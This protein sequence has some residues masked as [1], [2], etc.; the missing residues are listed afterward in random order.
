MPIFLNVPTTI[1]IDKVR[2]DEFSVRPQEN[3][4]TIHFSKGYEDATGQFIAKEF[5]RVDLK[6][7]AVDPALYVQIKD[8]LY[9]LLNDELNVRLTQTQKEV[10]NQ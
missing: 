8:V 6:N 7:V 9:T 5:D 3:S 2:I 4:V 1:T 10:N